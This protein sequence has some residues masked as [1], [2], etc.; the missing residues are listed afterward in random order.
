MSMYM[1]QLMR[2]DLDSLESVRQ[3]A[4]EVAG[5]GRPLHLLVNNAG[6][7]TMGGRVDYSGTVVFTS[8]I[9]VLIVM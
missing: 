5:L 3:F 9:L 1:L 7:F 6:V 4:K 2:L 8:K